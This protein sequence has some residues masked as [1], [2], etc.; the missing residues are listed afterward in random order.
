MASAA[1]ARIVSDNES[2]DDAFEKPKKTERESD[3][4]NQ[5]DLSGLGMSMI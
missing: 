4:E 2:E 1:A 5:S 3:N